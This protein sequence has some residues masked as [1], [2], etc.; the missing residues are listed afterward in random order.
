MLHDAIDLAEKVDSPQLRVCCE[1]N[2]A[3]I[4]R[5]LLD[6]IRDRSHL[7]AIV[8]INDFAEGTLATP[9]RVPVGDGII[10]L[11]RIFSAFE[12][13]GYDG[14]Y[15]LELIGPEIERLGY[16]EAI[17]R[18]VAWLDAFEPTDDLAD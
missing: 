14:Y 7:I 15:E 2:N 11:R 4:E 3:W 6:D 12:R 5:H 16:E 10:P 9:E 18:S 13:A 1:I 17:R 8:Q